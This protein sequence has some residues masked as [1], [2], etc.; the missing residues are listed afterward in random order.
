MTTNAL[1]FALQHQRGVKRATQTKLADYMGITV[2]QYRRLEYGEIPMSP[3]QANKVADF[4]GCGAIRDIYCNDW[5]EIGR[6]N[7]LPVLNQINVNPVAVMLKLQYELGTVSNAI[8]ATTMMVL[9][10]KSRD[11]FTREELEKLGSFAAL[12]VSLQHCLMH[13]KLILGDFVD[14]EKIVK[15]HKT[16][17]SHLIDKTKPPLLLARDEDPAPYFYPIE[18]GK[19]GK[20]HKNVFE[21]LLEAAEKEETENRQDR[22]P[23]GVQRKKNSAR[24]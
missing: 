2:R 10:K 4:L 23:G 6:R 17:C 11:D 3:A 22:K 12:A 14:V 19:G 18:G 13:V 20:R 21:Q 24:I 5:C 7:C 16:K 8:E 1:Y 15:A 9:N